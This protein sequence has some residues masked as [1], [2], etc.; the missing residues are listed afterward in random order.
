MSTSTIITATDMINFTRVGPERGLALPRAGNA[1][2]LPHQAQG[3]LPQSALSHS[4]LLEDH[5]LTPG[6]Y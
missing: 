4:G 2:G 6:R 3:K 5:R 1:A